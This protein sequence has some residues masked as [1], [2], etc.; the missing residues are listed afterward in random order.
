MSINTCYYYGGK[1]FGDSINNVFIN[2]LADKTFTYTSKPSVPH[3]IVTGSVLRYSTSNSIVFGTGFIAEN[4]RFD[5]SIPSKFIA[6]RGP[7][8]RNKLLKLQIDCPTIYGD[9][10]ILFPL[11]YS[12]SIDYIPN[13]IGIIPHYID[14]H[15]D[16]LRLLDSNLMS[17]RYTT[18]IIDIEVGTDYKKFID[19]I[20]KCEIIISSS[21]HGMMMGIVYKKPTILV[22]FSN[23]LVGDLFKFNDFFASLDINYTVKNIY[24]VDVLHNIIQ[25]DYT[26]VK[27]I[28]DRLLEVA[29]FIDEER[30]VYLR[31]QYRLY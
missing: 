9:P 19:T 20:M 10:L 6:V 21:L 11:M 4:S 15:T 2:F 13:V 1:N 14:K 16:T 3:Y 28:G 17:N 24:D 25:V 26:K 31:Q 18:R 23:K 5:S 22:Q 8:T 29:P 7:L 30:K 27:E 12:P